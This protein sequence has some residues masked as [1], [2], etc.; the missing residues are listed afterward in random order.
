[1][2]KEG[3]Q[4]HFFKFKELEVNENNEKIYI[5]INTAYAFYESV[6]YQKS[7]FIPKKIYALNLRN[8]T[9]FIVNSDNN[10]LAFGESA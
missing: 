6:I 8:K 2:E 10:L 4:I 7:L 1:M 3:I 9:N 5:R